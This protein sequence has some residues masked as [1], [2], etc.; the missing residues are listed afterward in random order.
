MTI[1]HYYETED[2]ER[3]TNLEDAE[4]HQIN[5]KAWEGATEQF[6]EYGTVRLDSYRDFKQLCKYMEAFK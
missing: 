5:Y 1:K 2:G 6:G 3:F 4:K